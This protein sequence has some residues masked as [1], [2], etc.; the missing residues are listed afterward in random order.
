MNMEIM[1]NT[2]LVIYNNDENKCPG[3]WRESTSAWRRSWGSS[4]KVLKRNSVKKD[5]LLMSTCLF[6][7]TMIFSERNSNEE[8]MSQPCRGVQGEVPS[9]QYLSLSC[10]FDISKIFKIFFHKVTIRCIETSNAFSFFD[11]H[12]FLDHR[13]G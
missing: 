9:G 1:T 4:R 11:Y 13:A 12:L 5:L 3:A 7:N 8:L 2:M 6:S 10:R